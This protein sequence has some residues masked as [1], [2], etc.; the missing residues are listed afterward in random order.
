MAVFA[1]LQVP[2]AVDEVNVVEEPTQTSDPA[3][4]VV[5]GFVTEIDLTTCI[6]HGNKV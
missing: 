5:G 6:A 1:E 4:T 2:P 3:K